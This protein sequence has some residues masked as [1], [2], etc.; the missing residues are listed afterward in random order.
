MVV[1]GGE[2]CL[3]DGT[4]DELVPVNLIAVENVVE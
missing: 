3:V 1:Q 4:T 2:E